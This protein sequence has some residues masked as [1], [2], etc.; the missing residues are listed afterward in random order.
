MNLLRAAATVSGLTLLSRITGLIR[1]NLTAAI[2]GASAHTDAFFVA[3]RLPNLLRRMFA[4]GA[5]SQAFVPILGEAK[6]R[7][8]A[9]GDRLAMQQFI[10]RVASAL[11][12]T[13]LVVSALGVAAAPWLVTLMASG[14]RAQPEVFDVAVT[15]TRWMFPYI[16]FVSLVALAAG[17]LNTWKRF[18]IPAFTPVL[19]NLCFIG[20]ALGLSSRFDPPIYALAAGVVIGGVAQLAI[21]VPAL[22]RIGVMPRLVGPMTAFADAGTRRVLRQMAPAL[23]AVSVAQISL[24]I[25]THIASRLAAG[26]VSWVSYGDR[27]M[28]FPTALLGVA[29]GTVLLPSLSRAGSLGDDREY[30]ALLD[31]GLRLCVVLA[32]P[33]MVGL[34]LMAEPLTALLFHYGRFGADDVEMTRRA[35][36]AYSVGL[37]G[38]VSIKVLAPGFYAKQDLKTPVKI[39][40]FVL[41]VTQLLNLITVPWLRHAGLALSISIGALANA[42]LLLAGLWRRGAW[43]PLPGWPRF[44][45]ATTTASAAMA[46]GLAS[47]VPGVD[48]IGLQG[49]PLLRVGLVL[50]TVTAA[51]LL[52]LAILG[53][54]GLRPS[55]FL[56]RSRD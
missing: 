15:M 53:A 35:V 33:C 51:G 38:L 13:L 52:Y 43:R 28:E 40:L 1:E 39:A 17:I 22:L 34:A 3:F 27:L 16:L 37:L 25:N 50:G 54:F 29:L 30:R 14:L 8:D 2:F 21:Q 32:A 41:V 31:W 19:L 42:G 49:Q 46:A 55:Q 48:W 18:A 11:F 9:A 26:S 4:E 10:D 5:F 24:I 12:W 36:A 20:A 44:L 23:L 45:L 6:T 47:V 7:A 56:R